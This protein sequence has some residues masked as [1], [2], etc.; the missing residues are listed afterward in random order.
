[1]TRNA[2]VLYPDGPRE[3]DTGYI[4]PLRTRTQ[5]GHITWTTDYSGGFIP[6]IST[7]HSRVTNKQYTMF[8]LPDPVDLRV[9]QNPSLYK[10]INPPPSPY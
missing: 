7:Y 2:D 10:S 6:S 4:I 3:R 8:A 1:M 5:I 9:I